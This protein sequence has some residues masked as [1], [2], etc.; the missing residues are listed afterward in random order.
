MAT[1]A[2][3][4]QQPVTKAP[5]H[6]SLVVNIRR[7]FSGAARLSATTDNGRGKQNVLRRQRAHLLREALALPL[8]LL[9]RLSERGGVPERR[10][11]TCFGRRRMIGYSIAYDMTD[12]TAKLPAKK[13]THQ[14]RPGATKADVMKMKGQCAR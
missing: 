9:E 5:I 7:A 12:A 13:I 14:R 3:C 6:E 4:A 10:S 1:R 8:S 2:A 11:Y